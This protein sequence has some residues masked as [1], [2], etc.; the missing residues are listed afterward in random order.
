M[1]SPVVHDLRHMGR[2][3]LNHDET[4]IDTRHGTYPWGCPRVTPC[5]TPRLTIG[6]LMCT[7]V[8]SLMN[9]PTV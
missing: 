1:L 5:P 7:P 2:V 4:H 9:H 8:K 6:C 3:M